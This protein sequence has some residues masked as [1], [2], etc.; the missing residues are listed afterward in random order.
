[1]NIKQRYSTGFTFNKTQ[2]PHSIKEKYLLRTQGAFSPRN[3][4]LITTFRRTRSRTVPS[5]SNSYWQPLGLAREK[6]STLNPE[7][8]RNKPN[9]ITKIKRRRWLEK[10]DFSNLN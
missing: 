1:M 4:R 10:L 7:Y 6:E 9:L 8:S 2:K 5:F 3:S